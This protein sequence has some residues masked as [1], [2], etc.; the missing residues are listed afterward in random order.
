MGPNLP[1]QQR[2]QA[3]ANHVNTVSCYN[4]RVIINNQNQFVRPSVEIAGRVAAL[5]A[6]INNPGIAVLASTIYYVF[7]FVA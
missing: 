5:K 3:V 4:L 2:L 6:Q 1:L 7:Y